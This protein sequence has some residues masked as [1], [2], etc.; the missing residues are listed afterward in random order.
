[1]KKLPAKSNKDTALDFEL[2][3]AALSSNQL[4]YL[5]VRR[6]AASADRLELVCRQSPN[7]RVEMALMSVLAAM[8]KMLESF[9]Y[10][11]E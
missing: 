9:E 1:L 11:P 5:I 2:N 6:M 3:D 10:E 8:W 4:K 7:F